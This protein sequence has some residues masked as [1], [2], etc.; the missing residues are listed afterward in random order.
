MFTHITDHRPPHPHNSALEAMACE[1]EL[2]VAAM[3]AAWV[4]ADEQTLAAVGET[5]DPAHDLAM[6]EMMLVS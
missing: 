2:E 5:A 1:D 6:A 3:E 4:R